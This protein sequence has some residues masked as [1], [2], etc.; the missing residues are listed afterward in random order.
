MFQL[1]RLTLKARLGLIAAT[2]FFALL[3]LAAISLLELRKTMMEDRQTKTRHLVEAAMGVL[4]HFEEMRAS[5]TLSAQDAKQLAAEALRDMRY[6]STEYFWINDLGRPYPKMVMHPTVPSLEGKTLDDPVF[7]KATAILSGPG[8]TAQ[9]LDHANLFISF[10]SVVQQHQRGF[11]LYEWPKPLTGGG[12][13]T[14]LYPK[15]SYVALFPPWD[16][17]V[18]SGVYIDDVESAFWKQAWIVIAIA[19]AGLAALG[20]LAMAIRRGILAELGSEPAVA[21]ARA[22]QLQTDKETA[23]VANVAKS[24]F[25]ANMSHEIRTPINSVIGMA[26]LA[27]RTGLD[28]KQRDYVEKILVSGQHLL[29]IVDDVLDFSKI[30]A[31]KMQLDSADFEFSAVT[32]K[33]STLLEG[34]A[35]AKGL[36][37]RYD[38]SPGIPAYLKG[39]ALRLEQVLINLVG[40]SIKFTDEGTIT[41]R[42]MVQDR[43]EGRVKLRFE[44]IDTGIGMTEIELDLL[45]QAFQQ[46]DSST[47]R[48]F[49][50]TGLGLAITKQLVTL[51]GG[52]IGVS[53]KPGRGSRFWFNVPLQ[54]GDE[55]QADNAPGS[56]ID[57]T[58][59]KGVQI[60]LAE[61]NVFNQQVATE[62]LEDVGAIVAVANN[63]AE[64]LELMQQRQF[65]CILMDLQMPIM[66]GL[67]AT[68]LIRAE[69]A[70][71]NVK[72]IAMTANASNDDR[73]R[74]REVGMDDFV[75]KPF[76]PEVLY[77]RI[78]S[79]LSHAPRNPS[80]REPV[81]G[82]APSQVPI[83]LTILSSSVRNDPLKLRKFA[84][85]FIENARIGLSEM[86]SA[87]AQSD[88]EMVSRL[89]HRMK[90]SARTVGAMGFAELCQT[91]EGLKRSDDLPQAQAISV[92][93]A[94]L[95]GQI[96][97]I[98]DQLD[99]AR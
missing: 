74:C 58:S 15:L 53:S 59:I 4:N 69:P 86:E 57:E 62:L 71:K 90:S 26:H 45:F 76:Q 32:K 17:V 46:A 22:Q 61:D 5:G 56:N 96:A 37:L 68:R 73:R 16:W 40:N 88:L 47:T 34:R 99:N 14:E 64:A 28:P 65:D 42:A 78:A 82:R 29:G 94:A 1:N 55:K 21:A 72:I 11:V 52:N 24:A 3:I 25:I 66:D 48:R 9:A 6:D 50:G 91:L 18:G 95:L 93:L 70:W 43:H 98:V 41:I 13:S 54:L 30:E 23:E 12:V 36:Y 77:D 27:L 75:S 44:V 89:G 79:I 10:N 92:Q 31:C 51:M 8:K 97:E 35:A 80:D 39:D 87:L 85:L 49:G 83:D 33:L 7:N 60:L 63:G 84:H 38:Y 67:S 19:L 2:G 20:G 81:A